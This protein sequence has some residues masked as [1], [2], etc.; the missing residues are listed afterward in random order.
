M[1]HDS[2][3]GAAEKEHST[4]VIAASRFIRQGILAPFIRHKWSYTSTR[5]ISSLTH[6]SI[7]IYWTLPFRVTIPTSSDE[8]LY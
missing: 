2:T 4:P 1:M 8:P 6:A 3:G 7:W 5:M